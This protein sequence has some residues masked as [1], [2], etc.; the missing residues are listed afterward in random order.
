MA[1]LGGRR[2]ILGGLVVI[3]VLAALFH[4]FRRPA[5]PV[6]PPTQLAATNSIWNRRFVSELS[7]DG[8]MKSTGMPEAMR[9]GVAIATG[10]FRDTRWEDFLAVADRVAAPD[11]W[12]VRVEPKS[13][14]ENDTITVTIKGDR[15]TQ[16]GVR[17][18]N[19]LKGWRGKGGPKRI[20]AEATGEDGA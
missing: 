5:K 3:S 20:G 7:S 13:G 4:Q 1:R 10:R 16:F 17:W 14:G 18:G 12:V 9:R 2:I 6:A 8:L 11:T 15:Y 19:R